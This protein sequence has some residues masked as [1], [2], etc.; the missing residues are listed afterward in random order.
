MKLNSKAT[1]NE[2]VPMEVFKEAQ[3]CFKQTSRLVHL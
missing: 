3:H 2:L 1:S